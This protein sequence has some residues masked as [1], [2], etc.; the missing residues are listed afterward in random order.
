MSKRF[1]TL[2]PDECA[3][4]ALEVQ[5]N[6]HAI[7]RDALR[8]EDARSYGT[9]IA[10]KVHALE[11][12]TKALLLFMDSHGFRFRGLTNLKVLDKDHQQRH[13]VI[14]IAAAF[15]VLGQEF[16]KALRWMDKNKV[17]VSGSELDREKLQRELWPQLLEYYR[18]SLG[19][20]MLKLSEWAAMLGDTRTSG[21]YTDY[22]DTLRSPLAMNLT[23]YSSVNT[24]LE[25][26]YRALRTACYWLRKGGKEL[27]DG[28]KFAKTKLGHPKRYTE[29]NKFIGENL[30]DREVL[31]KISQGL[32]ESIDKIDS[33]AEVEF[34]QEP[35]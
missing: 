4:T 34:G 24:R 11:E 1:Q 21:I 6:A 5:R 2:R 10:L 31:I 32:R 16:M 20:L 13:V 19:P 14:L 9:A 25:S 30:R 29:V 8:L 26:A 22:R 35:A 23:E 18:D 7:R 28:F 15:D 27:D 3:I 33:L 12:M 17:F